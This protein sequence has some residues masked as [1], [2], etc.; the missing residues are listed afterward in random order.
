MAKLSKGDKCTV[1]IRPEAIAVEAGNHK[2]AEKTENKFSL[3]VSQ[4]TYLGE[5][6]QLKLAYGSDKLLRANF[7]IQDFNLLKK[8][9]KLNADFKAADVALLPEQ[10]DLGPGT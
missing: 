9:K 5:S 3:K 4:I 1:S 6:E 10:E 8:T 7:T 2:V